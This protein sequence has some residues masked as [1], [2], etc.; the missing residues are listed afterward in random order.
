MAGAIHLRQTDDGSIKEVPDLTTMISDLIMETERNA[1]SI[2]ADDED[3]NTELKRQA[4]EIGTEFNGM[5][6]PEDFL[7]D[8]GK[9][10]EFDKTYEIRDLEGNKIGEETITE[11]IID[12]EPEDGEGESSDENE[13]DGEE[14]TE[15]EPEAAQGEELPEEAKT[16]GETNDQDQ[17]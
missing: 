5:E 8:H 12:I 16:E 11:L 6:L 17:E 3:L 7:L 14:P 1:L 2:I 13:E 4:D 9:S 10:Y 15:E